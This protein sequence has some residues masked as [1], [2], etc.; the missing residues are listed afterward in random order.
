MCSAPAGFGS[1]ARVEFAFEAAELY[2]GITEDR[3]RL[4]WHLQ[5]RCEQPP[6][7]LDAVQPAVVAQVHATLAHE[8]AVEHPVQQPGHG[9]PF[10]ASWLHGC[11]GT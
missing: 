4:L 2:P 6:R 7:F 9:G 8:V 5:H 11:D 3:A 10:P 1:T